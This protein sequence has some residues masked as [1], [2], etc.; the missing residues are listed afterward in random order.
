MHA[1]CM[2]CCFVSLYVCVCS[3]RGL[4]SCSVS[5]PTAQAILWW[6]R[7]P[8]AL[9]DSCLSSLGG[10]VSQA[11]CY[12]PDRPVCGSFL[13]S[14]CCINAFYVCVRVHFVYSELIFLTSQLS[15]TLL[16]FTWTLTAWCVVCLC[17]LLVLR[18]V[19]SL[20]HCWCFVSG[21]WSSLCFCQPLRFVFFPL[22]HFPL[23]SFLSIYKL[24]E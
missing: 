3:C 1:V 23:P 12:L 24:G 18:S 15:L 14:R 20:Q 2:R 17:C 22:F 10:D 7:W 21:K 6:D 4:M 11:V 13:C 8:N 19:C 16:H 5:T 9:I